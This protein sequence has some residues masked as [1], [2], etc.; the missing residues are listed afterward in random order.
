VYLCDR[1][2]SDARADY[3]YE[4]EKLKSELLNMGLPSTQAF[5]NTITAI[6][7]TLRDII[8]EMS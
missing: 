1:M 2:S 3:A 5:K 7:G 4:L 8:H 6:D